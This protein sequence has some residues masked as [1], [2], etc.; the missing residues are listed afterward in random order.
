MAKKG[1]PVRLRFGALDAS[2]SDGS[3]VRA[4]G[5]S[6]ASSDLSSASADGRGMGIP[7]ERYPQR[8]LAT[9]Q[10]A[11]AHVL[12]GTAAEPEVS[13][14]LSELRMAE[15]AIL[16]LG[17]AG[18]EALERAL[19]EVRKEIALEG[20]SGTRSVSFVEPRA[21]SREQL[22]P[23][24]SFAESR[25]HSR[26][27]SRSAS[28]VL[29]DATQLVETV[30]RSFSPSLRQAVQFQTA[31]RQ[32]SVALDSFRRDTSLAQTNS[33]HSS[34]CENPTVRRLVELGP[35]TNVADAIDVSLATLLDS[36]NIASLAPAL[37]LNL[38]V[39]TVADLEELSSQVRK[40]PSWPRSRANFSLLW[41][42]SYWNAWLGHLASSTP[43]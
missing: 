26:E 15:Q 25:V 33:R 13:E 3:R 30:R 2:F 8:Q 7:S 35:N 23:A 14:Q 28:T 5:M 18:D 1:R 9:P 39:A 17:P 21:K 34:W 40:K 24:V 22:R 11:G 16:A 43:T 19:A 42:Y 4:D 31:L 20:V 27:R 10:A 32:P 41:L 12:S 6:E 36:L 37:Y 38:G 29:N